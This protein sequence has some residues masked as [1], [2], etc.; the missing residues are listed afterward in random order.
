MLKDKY[1]IMTMPERRTG[2]LGLA[3]P[4]PDAVPDIE[5]A[6]LNQSDVQRLQQDR[7]KRLAPSMPWALIEPKA[8]EEADLAAEGSVTWG[9]DA[10]RATDSPFDGNGIVVAVLDTGIDLDHPVFAGVSIERRNFTSEIDDDINGHGTHC[11]GTIFGQDFDGTRIGV[12]PNIERALIGKV[13]GKGGSTQ[14]LV[15]AINWVVREGAHVIS[16]SLGIDFPGY[17]ADLINFDG[18]DP[19]PAT[20]LA[21]EAYR[22]NVNLFTDFYQFVLSQ[23]VFGEGI[24]FVAAAGNE[25]KR[26]KY[27]IATAPPAAATHIISVA[28]LAKGAKGYTVADF[29]NNQVDISAP[30]VGVISAKAGGGLVSKSGTSMATPHVAGVAALWAQKQFDTDGQIKSGPLEADLKAS[31]TKAPLDPSHQAFENVGK[32]IVQAPLS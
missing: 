12:A 5:V 32:G 2:N 11:A 9:I 18:L 19:E 25:S 3:G 22:Y 20:S 4:D 1:V 15:D 14:G 26:P 27:E 17:V 24:V 10:V 8:T 23:R 16:M 21:L 6:E 7:R 28:A 29:S 30:G 31:G 13:L